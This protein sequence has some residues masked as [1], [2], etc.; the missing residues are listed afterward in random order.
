GRGKQPARVVLDANLRI[1]RDCQLLRTPEISPVLIATTADAAASQ[2][3]QTQALRD[4]RA[5]LLE[6]PPARGGVDLPAL[7]DELGRRDWTY[8]LV[9]GGP[10]VQ[11]SFLQ[12]GLV[13]ELRVY[14][15]PAT[16]GGGNLPR[17]DIREVAQQRGL[18][19]AEDAPCGE[20]RYLRY[21]LPASPSGE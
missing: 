8:L 2:P 3:A 5:E 10:R 6:L 17:L 1:P 13:D 21:I 4:A 9:E 7:L 12:C 19:P 18:Q 15:S 14:V 20:D 16:A 11:R